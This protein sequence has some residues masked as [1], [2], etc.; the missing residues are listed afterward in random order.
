[1][2][3]RIV[4]FEESR[5]RR[6]KKEKFGPKNGDLKEKTNYKIKEKNVHIT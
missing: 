5:K 4:N 2:L 6:K 1:M 3:L